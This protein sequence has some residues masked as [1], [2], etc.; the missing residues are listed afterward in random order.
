VVPICGM[1]KERGNFLAFG[2]ETDNT[3]QAGVA[4]L[5]F[6][7][8]QFELRRARLGQVPTDEDPGG[9]AEHFPGALPG[10]GI[11]GVEEGI[12]LAPGILVPRIGTPRVRG[13]GRSYRRTERD[14]LRSQTVS[15]A[16]VSGWKSDSATGEGVPSPRCRFANW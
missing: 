5:G 14:D 11:G 12:D 13:R 6:L 9:T 3:G 10:G 7:G 16:C 15:S 2:R 8:R 1:E 4:L